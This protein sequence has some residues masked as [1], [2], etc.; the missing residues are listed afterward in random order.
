MDRNGFEQLCI[1]YAN[2][3]LQVTTHELPN[4]QPSTPNRQ[5][6]TRNPEPGTRN[7]K[8]ENLEP[9]AMHPNLQTSKPKP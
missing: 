5:P 6:G 2:E 1:N 3:K 9:N 4:P 8:L 7:S